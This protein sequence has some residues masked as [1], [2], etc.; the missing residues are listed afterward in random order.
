MYRGLVLV[1]QG[2]VEVEDIFSRL[3]VTGHQSLV[4][5]ILAVVVPYKLDTV[6]RIH[7][8]F[9][10]VGHREVEQHPDGGEVQPRH[11]L[12]LADVRLVETVRVFFIML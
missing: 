8:A 2:L 4:V 12:D 3:A 7:V 9:L 5:H 10:A 1:P 11:G 6:L